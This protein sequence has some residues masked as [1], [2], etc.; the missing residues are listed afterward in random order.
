MYVK[1]SIKGDLEQ[2][3]K[4]ADI[5]EDIYPNPDPHATLFIPNISPFLI[6]LLAS[7]KTVNNKDIDL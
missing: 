1:I 6:G 4:M 2:N 7:Q 3:R 5:N